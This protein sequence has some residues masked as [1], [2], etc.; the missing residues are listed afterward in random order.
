MKYLLTGVAAIAMLTACGPKDKPADDVAADSA[1][2]AGKELADIKVQKGDPDTAAAALKALYLDASGA[3]RATFES[4]SL[5]GDKAVFKNVTLADISDDEDDDIEV[6][7]GEV[8]AETLELDGLAMVDGQPSFGRLVMKGI[9]FVPADDEEAEGSAS[10]GSMELINPSAETAAW[11]ATV[12]S[13]EEVD[14]LP[15]GAAL[16]F[17]KFAMDKVNFQIDEEDGEKGSFLVDYLGISSLDEQTAGQMLVKNLSFDMFDPEDDTTV[18]AN[19]GALDIR[20]FD[21]KDLQDAAEDADAGDFSQDFMSFASPEDPANPGYDTIS[22]SG[23]DI[24]VSGLNFAMPSL[25]S[26][27]SRDKQGRA[28]KVVTDPFTMTLKTGEGELGEELG[29]QLATLGY[30]TL[31]LTGASEQNYDPDTDIV[32]L[33]K[34][35]NYWTL[36]DGFRLDLGMK[37]EGV[38]AMAAAQESEE[39]DEDNPM[40]MLDSTFEALTFHNLELSLD[41]NGIVDRAFNAYA[42]QTGEDPVQLRSQTAGL[43]AMA[44]MMASGSGVDMEL[45]TELSA[46]LSSFITE[47]KT[48]TIKLDPATPIKASTFADMEDPSALTKSAL[49][50]SAVNE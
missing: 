22:M 42:A 31:E 33:E 48:L 5:D 23:L 27:V 35:K 15:E 47:P 20:G 8:T 26:N 16:S 45:V 38:S 32:T 49:G 2:I 4:S 1:Q 3:G 10:I 50:F 40:E 29:A 14:D 39:F 46:A 17:D 18:K 37:Y 36:K 19:L 21:F 34:G 43:L 25:S 9:S 24:D 12:F 41:D 11:V 28:V 6:T 7:E 30:E 44:P 13:N